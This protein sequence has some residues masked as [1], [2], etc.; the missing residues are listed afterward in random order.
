MTNVPGVP[1]HGWVSGLTTSTLPG[2]QSLPTREPWWVSTLRAFTMQDNRPG[3]SN[4]GEKA[5]GSVVASTGMTCLSCSVPRSSRRSPP[6]GPPP[7]TVS[8]DNHSSRCSLQPG[9]LSPSQRC[10][11]PA[12]RSELKLSS[13]WV[14]VWLALSAEAKSLQLSAVRPQRANLWETH[15][16]RFH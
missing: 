8:E 11:A 13:R 6:P 2:A 7:Q 16:C 14:R 15:T 4:I 10:S 3:T 9:C 12:S 5:K 1:L